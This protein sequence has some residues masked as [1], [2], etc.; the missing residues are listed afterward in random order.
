MK[1][2]LDIIL[3]VCYP[4]LHNLTTTTG[5]KKERIKNMCLQGQK[6]LRRNKF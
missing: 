3:K 1:I 4:M 2:I 6:I 5:E